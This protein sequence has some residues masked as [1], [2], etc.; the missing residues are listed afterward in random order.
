[1]KIMSYITLGLLYATHDYKHFTHF[2]KYGVHHSEWVLV[3]SPFSGRR[4]WGTALKC[5]IT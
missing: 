2:N 3:F 4:S 1:M 5:Q